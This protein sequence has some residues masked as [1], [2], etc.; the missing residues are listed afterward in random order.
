MPD[1]PFLMYAAENSFASA[2]PARVKAFLAAYREAIDIL[3]KDDAVW[4][5]RGNIMKLQGEALTL[6]RDEAREDMMSK[7]QP[8]TEA[9][10]RKV[11]GVLL[12][13]G[14]AQLIGIDALPKE[15]MTLTYQ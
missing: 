8:N 15:F 5:E 3:N 2:N 7:F 4:V 10:I 6:F 13:T 11:F 14:G 9:D 12:E 1:T